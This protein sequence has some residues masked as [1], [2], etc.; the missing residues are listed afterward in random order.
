MKLGKSEILT[1]I[2]MNVVRI[3]TDVSE[4]RI[5]SIFRVE[6]QPSKEP[7]CSRYCIVLYCIYFG[8]RNP[9]DIGQVNVQ[10]YKTQNN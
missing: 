9:E 6:N 1:V 10:Q 8:P 3:G 5:I 2:V 4:E 7:A